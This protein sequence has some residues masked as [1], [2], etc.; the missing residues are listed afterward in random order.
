[1]GMVTTTIAA[2]TAW[3]ATEIWTASTTTSEFATLAT[4]SIWNVQAIDCGF[5]EPFG[6]STATGLFG[7]RTGPTAETTERLSTSTTAISATGS[8]CEFRRRRKEEEEVRLF[9]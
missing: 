9:K 6:C 1:M 4:E 5:Y 7:I 3:T 2:T 8:A